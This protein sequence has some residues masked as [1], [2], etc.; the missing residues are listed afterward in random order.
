MS[1]DIYKKFQDY[2][3]VFAKLSKEDPD[4]LK[5]EI[6][7][8]RGDAQKRLSELY[9]KLDTSV[10]S[11]KT[12]KGKILEKV[13]EFLFVNNYMY[14]VKTN[15]RD[16]SNEIDLLLKLNDL[17]FEEKDILPEVLKE[18]K[19]F[20]IECKN[21]SSKISVT[22]IG[23]FYS[24]LTQRNLKLGIIISVLPVAGTGE[25]ASS[26]GL[27]KKIYLKDGIVI[28][29]IC[30]DDI[31]KIKNQESDLITLIGH[32]YDDLKYVTDLDRYKKK[33]PAEP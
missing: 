33:H 29:N 20:I 10:K 27:I 18:N 28:L 16:A 24:L 7:E 17:G 30:K 21:Y 31:L 32:K 3:T 14:E 12:S 25:W 11:K 5:K 26:K 8:I 19:E 6:F 23:K 15:I 2:R 13:S 4:F 22:W 9:D 1:D